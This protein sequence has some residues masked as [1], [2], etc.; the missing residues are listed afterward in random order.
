MNLNRN[1]SPPERNP[2][3]ATLLPFKFMPLDAERYV[4]VNAGGE[5]IVTDRPAIQS[6]VDACLPPD[7]PQA[8]DFEARHFIA[9]DNTAIGMLASQVRTR[10]SMLPDFTGLHMFVVTLRCDHSCQYC[11]V[12]RVSEDR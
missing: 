6:L 9:R 1:F 10:L 4:A 3:P 11:Q 2:R 12:S 8:D 7:H 5:H